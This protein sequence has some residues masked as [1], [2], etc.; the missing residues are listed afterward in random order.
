M[1]V[2]NFG[3]IYIVLDIY[4]GFN[5]G[6]VIFNLGISLTGCPGEGYLVDYWKAPSAQA[7]GA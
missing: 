3:S 7:K 5:Q 6:R 2:W 4:T 1:G